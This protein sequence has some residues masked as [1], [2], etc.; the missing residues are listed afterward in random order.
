MEK[1]M[2]KRKI[3]H[4]IENFLKANSGKILLVNGAR[5]VGKTFII[6]Y[7]GTKLYKNFVE[8]NMLTDCNGNRNFADVKTTDDFYMQLALLGGERLG[9]A[10]DT[11]VFIDEI[12]AYPHLLTMLKFLSQENKFTYIAS[13]SLLGVS[14]STTPSIPIGSIQVIQMYPLDM[15]EFL[16][17]NNVNEEAIEN[18]KISF[19][20]KETVNEATHNHIMRLLKYYLI[21][22]G[23]PEA[24]NVF[25]ETKNIVRLRNVQTEIHKYYRLDASQYDTEHKLKIERVYD[26]IPSALEHTKKRIIAKNIENEGKKTF[27]S[28]QDEFDY[29]ISSG[30]ALEVKAVSNPKF[31]LLESAKKNLLKLYLNDV[32][33]LSNILYGKNFNAILKDMASINL[34]AM[35]ESFVAQELSAHEFNLHYFDNKKVGE[36]DFLINDFNNL[37]VLPLEIKSGRDYY[38]HSALNKFL[39]T[40]DYSVSRAIVFSNERNVFIKNGIEYYPIYNVMFLN[41]DAEEEIIP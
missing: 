40:P 9:N 20:N 35:Y 38:V 7:I 14:L 6:R 29:L 1:V 41:N 37:K 24:V 10:E 15:E 4:T 32:G 30:I 11:L 25:V 39:N 21:S 5:Q 12:Q 2:L 16:W 34:G 13:G 23:L 31:P 22:G 17:A 28:Y 18:L 36:V 33:I 3:S 26:Y 8:I 27:A 19:L